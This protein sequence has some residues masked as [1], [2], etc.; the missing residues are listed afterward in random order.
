MNRVT[1]QRTTTTNVNHEAGNANAAPLATTPATKA[2]TD[3]TPIAT[4][5]EDVPDQDLEAKT[6]E[7]EAE[8]EEGMYFQIY[9]FCVHVIYNIVFWSFFIVT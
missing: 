3:A 5:E 9:T 4:V 8:K 6:E 7:E 2:A 1:K